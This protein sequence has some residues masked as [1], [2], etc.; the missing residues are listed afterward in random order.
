[1]PHHVQKDLTSPLTKFPFL[2][3]VSE[4]DLCRAH[5]ICQFGVA[6]AIDRVQQC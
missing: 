3:K 4:H 2:V 6:I 5:C 1:M